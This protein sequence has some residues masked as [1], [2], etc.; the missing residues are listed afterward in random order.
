[1]SESEIKVFEVLS[2]FALIISLFGPSIGG[3]VESMMFVSVL[4]STISA[5]GRCGRFAIGLNFSSVICN[6]TIL[7]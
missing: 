5:P 1:M 7:Y 3:Y 6:L 4:S 2:I